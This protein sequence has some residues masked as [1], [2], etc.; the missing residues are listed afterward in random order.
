MEQI[1]KIIHA[2]NKVEELAEALEM[3][4]ELKDLSSDPNPVFELLLAWSIE[5]QTYAPKLN[6]RSHLTHQL[7]TIGMNAVAH[8]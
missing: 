3:S 6:L 7:N 1:G 8:R 5:M 2:E 4:N